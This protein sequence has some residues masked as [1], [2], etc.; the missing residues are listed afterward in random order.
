MNNRCQK[1]PHVSSLDYIVIV[2][3]TGIGP[4]IIIWKNPETV[5]IRERTP[6]GREFVGLQA[7]SDLDLVLRNPTDPELET[8]QR[9]VL[10]EAFVESDLPIHVDLVEWSMIPEAFRHEIELGYVILQTAGQSAS[11]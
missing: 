10:R 1:K 7:A 6:N 3:V 4:G 5:S 9:H 2:R 8:A 11:K